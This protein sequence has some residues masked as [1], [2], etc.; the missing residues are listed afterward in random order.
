MVTKNNCNQRT[1]RAMST[2]E[3]NT[4]VAWQIRDWI[5]AIQRQDLQ[6]YACEL[7][8]T[9]PYKV[10]CMYDVSQNAT[11]FSN[12]IEACFDGTCMICHKNGTL[13][14]VALDSAHVSAM[15]GCDH[16]ACI[17]CWTVYSNQEFARSSQ[18]QCPMCRSD[19]TAFLKREY[20]GW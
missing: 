6:E 18:A 11:A 20:Y 10:R 8:L 19:I 14:N 3:D 16:R 2:T 4:A 9:F 7:C 15:P 17:A 12:K 13:D 1:D 5:A